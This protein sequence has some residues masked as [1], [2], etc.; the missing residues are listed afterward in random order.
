MQVRSGMFVRHA[1]AIRAGALVRRIFPHNF[2]R[3]VHLLHF[4][5]C[6]PAAVPKAIAN[7]SALAV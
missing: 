7:G 2:L 3:L 1:P 6:F 5:N 4:Q